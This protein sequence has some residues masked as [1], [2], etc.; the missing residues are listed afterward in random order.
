[1]QHHKKQGKIAR[2][3][4][5]LFLHNLDNNKNTIQDYKEIVQ[6]GMTSTIRLPWTKK[7]NKNIKNS[8]IE[9]YKRLG[10][11][12]GENNYKIYPRHLAK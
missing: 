11:F 5:H 7:K 3:N 10:N 6:N 12:K 9:V 1:M 8:N 2:D 4:K